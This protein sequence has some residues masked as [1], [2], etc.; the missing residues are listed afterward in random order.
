MTVR[1]PN[2]AIPPGNLLFKY[3]TKICW[4]QQFLLKKR[5]FLIKNKQYFA[6]QMIDKSDNISLSYNSRYLAFVKKKDL[7]SSAILV[8]YI[9]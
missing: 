2:C 7:K 4:A 8:Y 1:A 9:L 6:K 3:S 5:N